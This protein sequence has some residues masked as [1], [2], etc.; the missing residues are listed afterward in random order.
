MEKGRIVDRKIAFKIGLALFLTGCSGSAGG[1]TAGAP[2]APS[3]SH[4]TD[5]N[6]PPPAQPVQPKISLR[7]QVVQAR[8]I[9]RVISS[10]RFS[11]KTSDGAVV[12]G[13]QV[14][15]KDPSQPQQQIDWTGLPVGSF[16]FQLELLDSSGN[17][18]GSYQQAV[19]LEL[20]QVV[21]ISDPPWVEAPTP[22]AA[23]PPYPAGNAPSIS[24]V[25]LSGQAVD[26]IFDSARN[27]LYISRGSAVDIYDPVS[28]AV[29]SSFPL[30]TTAGRMDLSLDGN[31]LLVCVPGLASVA[32]VDLSTEPQSVS[33]VSIPSGTAGSNYPF[34]VAALNNG[35]ALVSCSRSNGYSTQIREI[36]LNSKTARLRNDVA[37]NSEVYLASSG[38]RSRVLIMGQGLS[39]TSVSSYDT[40]TD[41]FTTPL[42]ISGADNF[43][44]MSPTGQELWAGDFLFNPSLQRTGRLDSAG[45]GVAFSPEGNRAF[46][47]TR[48]GFNQQFEILDVTRRLTCYSRPMPRNLTGGMAASSDGRRVFAI[49]ANHLLD[50]D[51]GPN[52]AP[53]PETL[54]ECVVPIGETA[55]FQVHALDPDGDRLAWTVGVL[56]NGADFN[57]DTQKLR[58][59]PSGG[60]AGSSNKAVLYA[61]DGQAS[62]KLEISLKIAEAGSHFT[63]VPTGDNLSRLVLDRDR[64]RVYASNSA[65]NRV[66][67]FALEGC[68]HLLSLETGQAPLGLDLTPDGS[69]LLVCNSRTGFVQFWQTS[70]GQRSWELL[71][72][73][74][75]ADDRVAYT[76]AISRQNKAVVGYSGE[77]TTFAYMA[78]LDIPTQDIRVR[79]DSGYLIGPHEIVASWDRSRIGILEQ[80]SSSCSLTEYLDGSF[81]EVVDRLVY[82]RGLSA[83]PDGSLW[84]IGDGV[85]LVNSQGTTV[86]AYS[87]SPLQTPF[88]AF[89]DRNRLIRQIGQTGIQLLTA[90]SSAS[91]TLDTLPAPLTGPLIF[92]AE[93]NLLV[94]ASTGRL[95]FTKVNLPPV[96]SP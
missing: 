19:Q 5:S 27:R 37:P 91:T 12:R 29:I 31:L 67:S 32:L 42:R 70:N 52:L 68:D 92:D 49:A 39:P 73:G 4:P 63:V 61:S 77:T 60:A 9:D 15:P 28:R 84:A 13:P 23:P 11:L 58:F 76:T 89:I 34:D 40:A 90:G 22:G 82:P 48:A 95:I 57:P 54:A 25:S 59:A 78:E 20:E 36:D 81:R 88:V 47:V 64:H 2:L 79:N 71:L 55:S 66:E 26:C 93:R 3:N 7:F 18:R 38:P 86:D 65:R 75:V 50:I 41:S 1:P 10:Y 74:G 8:A 72:P 43:A 46:R 44:A 87:N 83:N 94:A 17:V 33:Y 6:S 24:D 45:L 53:V 96:P 35:K 30:S 62:A 80:S 21:N 16:F 85:R 51:L 14:F 69:G 56:P